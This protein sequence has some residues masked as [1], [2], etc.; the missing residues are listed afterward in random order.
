M[1]YVL[2]CVEGSCSW[3]YTLP[4][5]KVASQ[6]AE[7]HTKLCK[8]HVVVIY[9]NEREAFYQS[10]VVGDGTWADTYRMRDSDYADTRHD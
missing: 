9:D 10:R 7:E 5:Y 2:R 3:G 6:C 1:S 8:H 4:T